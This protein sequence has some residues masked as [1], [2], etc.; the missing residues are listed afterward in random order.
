HLLGLG[1]S[2][3]E[4]IRVRAGLRPAPTNDP[5]VRLSLNFNHVL[6]SALMEKGQGDEGWKFDAMTLVGASFSL[7]THF[8]HAIIAAGG[9]CN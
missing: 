2:R 3:D 1:W 9:S 5:R 4:F 7:A 8:I 6:S